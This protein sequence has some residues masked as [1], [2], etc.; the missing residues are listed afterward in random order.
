LR[1]VA[2]LMAALALLLVVTEIGSYLTL[3]AMASREGTQ[4]P[5]A[6]NPAYRDEPWAQTYWREHQQF[7][8]Q[9]WEAYPNGLWRSR[10]F[11]GKTIVVDND[12]IRRTTD[13]ICNGKTP[14]IYLFGGSTAW[15]YG[16]PDW[17]T[18][19]SHLAKR[20]ASAGAPACVVNMANDAW[21]SNEGVINLVQQLKK[22]G[23]RQPDDVVF[24]DGC[25]DIITPFLFTG[26]VDVPWNFQKPWLDARPIELR[27]NLHYLEVTNTAILVQRLLKQFSGSHLKLLTSA[28]NRL[29]REVVDNYLNNIRI[30]R[31]LAKSFDF[32]YAFFWVPV[33]AEEESSIFHLP[34]TK[35]NPL[36]RAAAPGQFHDLT[37]VF[38]KHPGN[39]ALDVCH[40]V[41]EGNKIVADQ[42]YEVLKRDSESLGH[43]AGGK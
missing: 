39:L 15:G 8:A 26:G 11:A 13:S 14:L 35:T 37:D 5:E 3:H 42:I 40:L 18:I 31:G 6:S 12:G 25:N 4:L 9:L 20:F 33:P 22:V 43:P 7:E 28:P 32:R 17:E 29:A 38:E 27:G 24:V 1:L 19:A 23:A 21:S 2:R 16:S 30:V 36:I 34:V 10:P 41:P